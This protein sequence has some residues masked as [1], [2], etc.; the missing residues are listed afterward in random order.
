MR[1]L[2][3]IRRLL[4]DAESEGTN[5]D[6]IFVDPDDTCSFDLDELEEIVAAEED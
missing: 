5:P 6:T 3:P 2:V 4:E 1:R